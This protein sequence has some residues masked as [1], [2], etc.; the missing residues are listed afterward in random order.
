MTQENHELTLVWWIPEQFWKANFASSQTLTETQQER[1]LRVLR[2]YTLVVVIHGDVGGLG[3]ITYHDEK[4]IR[5]E[6]KLVDQAGKAYTPL[7]PEDYSPDLDN[8]VTMMR[9]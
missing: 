1:F 4:S 6:L 7:A 5:K 8:F 3:A 2:P 9:P